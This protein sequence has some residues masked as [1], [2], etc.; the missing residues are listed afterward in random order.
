MIEKACRSCHMI[1][2]KGSVCPACKTSS[3]SGD[4]AGYVVI[5]DPEN[6]TIAKKLNVSVPGRYA[7]RVR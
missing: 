2:A 3:L 4:W 5:L 6:S 1:V 7:L